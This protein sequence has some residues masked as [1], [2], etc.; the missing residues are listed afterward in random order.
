MAELLI[1][2]G[3]HVDARNALD[4]T[5]LH[6]AVVSTAEGG[7]DDFLKFLIDRGANPNAVNKYV[8]LLPFFCFPPLC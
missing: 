3:A 8:A 5:P 6:F 4:E 1:A 7:H 2:F